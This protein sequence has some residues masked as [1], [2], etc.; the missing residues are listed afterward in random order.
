MARYRNPTELRDGVSSL[1]KGVCATYRHCDGERSA[2]ETDQVPQLEIQSLL[3]SLGELRKPSGRM[4]SDVSQFLGKSEY[5]RPSF[6]KILYAI[7]SSATEPSLT[8]NSGQVYFQ[9]EKRA[10]FS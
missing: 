5:S 7:D 8:G 10:L 2:A 1:K 6:E 3:L 9:R 4:P